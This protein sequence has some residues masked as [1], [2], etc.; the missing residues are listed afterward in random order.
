VKIWNKYILSASQI[1][2]LYGYELNNPTVGNNIETNKQT[3][4]QTL[5]ILDYIRKYNII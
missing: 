1:Q 4:K 2:N 5:I 3:N